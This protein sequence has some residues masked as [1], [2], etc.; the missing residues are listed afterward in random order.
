MFGKYKTVAA[1]LLATL[2]VLYFFAGARQQLDGELVLSQ[3]EMRSFSVDVR[4]VGELEAASSLTISSNLRAEQAKIIDLVSDGTTV[5]KGDLLVRLDPTPFEEKLEQLNA[6]ILEQEGMI[7]ALSQSLEVEKAQAIKEQQSAAFEIESA[8]LELEKIQEGD[9]PLEIARLKTI[10]QKA[11]AKHTELEQYA[12]D[13]RELEAEGF[14]NP[15]EARQAAKRMQE[16]KEEFE[17]AQLQ[18]QTYV[19]RV[20]P[21]QVKRAES[22][23]RKAKMLAGQAT[24]SSAIKIARAE[25]ALISGKK[26]MESLLASR[27]E[28]QRMLERCHIYAPAPGMVVLRRQHFQGT[29]RPARNGDSVHANQAL[30][31]LP[32]LSEMLVNTQVREVD[33]H[34]VKVGTPVSINVDAYPDLELTGTVHSIGVLAMADGGSSKRREKSF[35]VTCTLDPSDAPLRP[36]MTAR[37]NIHAEAEHEALTIPLHALK[38]ESGELHCYVPG[39]KGLECK[40]VQVGSSNAQYVEVLSGLHAGD[41]VALLRGHS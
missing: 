33:L 40:K 12:D 31:D 23:L 10:M 4:A 17:T 26:A 1:A 28:S 14:L 11:G 20:Y 2:L 8:E 35:R 15:A 37:V 30:I 32:D 7:E 41:K 25:A 36:G 21:M 3:A 38:K 39:N 6:K 29:R 27:R 22:N 16:A 34:K 18:Y 5:N 9:G 13:I 24:K 19:N